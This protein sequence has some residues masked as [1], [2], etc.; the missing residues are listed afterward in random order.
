MGPFKNENIYIEAK[1]AMSSNWPRVHLKPVKSVK[2]Q[3][4]G[5]RAHLLSE[6][7]SSQ[8]S[9]LYLVPPLGLLLV[10]PLSLLPVL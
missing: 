6:E 5:L 4:R 1:L 8:F 3:K 9:A 7:A 10:P 2:G